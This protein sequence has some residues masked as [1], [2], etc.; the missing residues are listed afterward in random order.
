MYD[1]AARPEHNSPPEQQEV[2]DFHI[3]SYGEELIFLSGCKWS[4]Q[5]LRHTVTCLKLLNVPAAASDN[6]TS[7]TI[8]LYADKWS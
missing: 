2:T 3:R 1:T 5:E 8:L 7:N 6:R 4:F